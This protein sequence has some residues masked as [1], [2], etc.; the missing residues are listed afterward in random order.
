MKLATFLEDS[1]Y[2]KRHDKL[3]AAQAQLIAKF[4]AGD[5]SAVPEIEKL[6]AGIAKWR[7][8]FYCT[9]PQVVKP[10]KR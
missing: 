6:A 9:D 3:A 5:K 4:L 1:G 8:D 10:L 2:W 7:N